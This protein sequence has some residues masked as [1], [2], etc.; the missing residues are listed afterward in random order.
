MT[1]RCECEKDWRHNKFCSRCP[2]FPKNAKS[3][4]PCSGHGTCD[5]VTAKCQCVAGWGGPLAE[6]CVRQCPGVDGQCSGHGTCNLQNGTCTCDANFVGKSCAQLGKCPKNCQGHGTCLPN[7]KCRCD[8]GFQNGPSCSANVGCPLDCSGHGQCESNGTCSCEPS[9]QGTPDCRLP[10]TRG[11][12]P[13]ANRTV[14]EVPARNITLPDGSKVLEPLKPAIV[15]PQFCANNCS[16]H[17]ECQADRKCLCDTGFT[18]TQDCRAPETRG[19]PPPAPQE[20][21]PQR[22]EDVL[23]GKV[24]QT[25]K[26]RFCP[27]NCSSHGECQGDLTCACDEGFAATPDCRSADQRHMAPLKKPS[28]PMNCNSHGVCDGM[29]RGNKVCK[30]DKGFAATPDCR[31]AAERGDPPK[32]PPGFVTKVC[33]NKCSG[34]GECGIDGTCTCDTGYQGK[35]DCSSDGCP[36]N[37][38]GKGECIRG[39]CS[40]L[41]GFDDTNDCRK[42][43]CPNKCSGHG[44]CSKGK[45][46]CDASFMGEDCAKHEATPSAPM[47]VVV[48]KASAAALPK[49][50]EDA[51]AEKVAKKIHIPAPPP[52]QAPVVQ[53]IQAPAIVADKQKVNEDLANM[54]A[55][56]L[57]ELMPAKAKCPNDCSGHGTCLPTGKCKCEEPYTASADCAKAPVSLEECSVCCGFQCAKKCKPKLEVSPEEYL[58]C[59]QDCSTGAGGDGSASAHITRDVSKA[60]VDKFGLDQPTGMQA[61]KRGDTTTADNVVAAMPPTQASLLEVDA[62][63]A[64]M[65]STMHLEVAGHGSCMDVCTSGTHPDVGFKCHQ[66]LDDLMSS[67]SRTELP[68]EIRTVVDGL[69][70]DRMKFKEASVGLSYT[71]RR[72]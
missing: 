12:P 4:T 44:T 30:C 58:A 65:F 36:A 1:G 59:Y 37:C 20:S 27:S 5:E 47:P 35:P 71:R 40:C 32:M 43:P 66:T 13:S 7:N 34:H 31:S 25:P 23:E 42:L 26:Q 33:P 22:V 62:G 41:I 54:F 15:L 50:D 57:K 39:K 46:T 2:Q 60:D 28:C 64:G 45:C 63:R 3:Y 18:G 53:V 8:S 10:E 69:K 17:G 70:K 49:V 6:A 19:L 68:T 9:F 61:A 16:G 55:G 48:E 24:P 29:A 52:V 38:N 67:S 21:I 56:K 72:R 14:P 11:L 51:I